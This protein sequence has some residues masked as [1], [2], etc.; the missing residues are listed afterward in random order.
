MEAE[1]AWGLSGRY[2]V[3]R[4]QG[5]QEASYPWVRPEVALPR[6]QYRHNQSGGGRNGLVSDLDPTRTR[7]RKE[8][9]Q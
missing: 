6:S 5:R 1:E 4:Y 9:S 2:P 8:W 3:L 7:Q